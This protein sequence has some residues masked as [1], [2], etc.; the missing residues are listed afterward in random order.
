MVAF[1]LEVGTEELPA[2]FVTD[3]LGQWRQ[4]IPASLKENYLTATKISYYGT[5]RRLAVL[6]E[7]LPDHQ[8]D[9]N[10]EIKG[11]SVAAAYSDGEP[12]KA[13]WG[14]VRSKGLDIANL[15][16]KDTEKGSFVY[17]TQSVLGKKT[18]VVLEAIAPSWITGLEG[19]RLM[20]WGTGELKFPRP[21]RWLVALVDQNILPLTLENLKS[22]RRSQG[23]RVLHPG[24]VIIDTAIDYVAALKEAFVIVDGAERQQHICTQI[25][26]VSELMRAQPEMPPQLLEEVTYLVE[27][28]TA[29]V[30]EFDQEFL[31][32][33]EVV[34][35]TE[36]VSHQRYFP[37]YNQNNQLLPKSI[38]ISNG[39][40]EKSRL[41]A[42]GNGRVIRARL[43]DGQFFYN[44]DRSQSLES[45][46]P[47]LEKVTF[48]EQLGSMAAKVQRITN[49]AAAVIAAIA[50]L[51]PTTTEIDQIKRTA[52]LSKAD[53]VTS[54]V[55]EF[56]E[57]QGIMG[58]DY[59]RSS[60]EDEMVAN[61]ILEHYLPRGAGD[62]L[63]QTLTGKIIAISDRIDTLVGIFG[64]GLIPTG[65][66][67]P[68]ALRR[69][70]AAIIQIAWHSDYELNLP[71]LIE[72]VLRIYQ[73]QITLPDQ[74]IHKNLCKWFHQRCETLLKDMGIDYDLVNAVVNVDSLQNIVQIRDQ[75][76]FLQASRSNGSLG[77]VYEVV[78]R[79]I[80]LADQAN[81]DNKT[82][83]I[84]QVV[85]RNRLCQPAETALYDAIA[86]LVPNPTY[87][88]LLNALVAITP[89]LSRFFAEVLVM[90]E[91]LQ[92][93]SDRLSLLA[94]MRNYS[95]ILADF[96][97]INPF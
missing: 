43:A 44:S 57:L 25:R 7:G 50:N 82:I 54:M 90:D 92:V 79:A 91:D 23:H 87:L 89:V 4:K 30:G 60:N 56:P 63:P 71:N 74:N 94:V 17:G 76:Q 21:I 55:K 16:V 8:L 77:E 9:Q 33:P 61:G 38:T 24:T 18:D 52:H 72:Y 66:S 62:Q 14:F 93:R 40:P 35:K 48:Q 96:R 88:E 78:N 95:Q 15:W 29:V 31:H 86:A 59:A 69:S 97:L 45:F 84:S 80:R 49:I 27:Y 41:I 1:L 6:I 75:S 83:D 67:D 13:L 26:G 58:S 5:P 20:R 70:A 42:A 11:P 3:A 65:S 39:D 68:F 81:L 47:L 64:L 34:I 51:N 46:L 28:P 73:D 2:G 12:T 22:N 32:L 85:D 53:L 37:L 36:M 19:R 10:L